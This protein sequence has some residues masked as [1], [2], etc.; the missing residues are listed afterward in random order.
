MNY[1]AVLIGRLGVSENYRG[2]GMNIGIKPG[3]TIG[4]PLYVLRPET[5]I[6]LFGQSIIFLLGESVLLWA[7][8]F[9]AVRRIASNR[10]ITFVS[11]TPISSA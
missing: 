4:N 11:N 8:S 2:K 7:S 6:K 1:P 9:V 3:G 5:Q 10:P